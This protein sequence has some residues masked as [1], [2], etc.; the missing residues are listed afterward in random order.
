MNKET[1]EALVLHFAQK[2][3]S[4]IFPPDTFTQLDATKASAHQAVQA[5]DKKITMP[6][7]WDGV[8]ENQS[9]HIV[10]KTV[11]V[12]KQALFEQKKLCLHYEGKDKP[13][14]F[15]P[16]GL[17]TRDQQYFLVG[18]YWDNTEPFLLSAR[19]V[20]SLQLS[21]ETGLTPEDDFNLATFAHDY[22]NH[23][24]SPPEIIEQLIVEFP[25]S[26][27]SYVKNYP[28]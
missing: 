18:S 4:E 3:L 23:P 1:A 13:F 10:T 21:D 6:S 12:F 19:K 16:F 27:Y 15:N 7:H 5:W 24:Q 26:V 25:A 22:L 11:D 2:Y 9:K 28:L 17:V 20:L 8:I 14:S